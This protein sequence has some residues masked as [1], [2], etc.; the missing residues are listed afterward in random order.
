MTKEQAMA[1]HFWILGHKGHGVTELRIFDPE[2]M[3]AYT[4][5]EDA[6]IGLCLE[7]ED[8]TQK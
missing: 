8:T 1:N 5:N 4:D 7:M 2:P 3:V 6:F